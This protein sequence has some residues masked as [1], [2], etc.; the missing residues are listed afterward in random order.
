[1]EPA[2]IGAAAKLAHLLRVERGRSQ[3]IGPLVRL[4]V[5]DPADERETVRVNAG[6]RP[7]DHDVARPDS[8]SVDQLR[9]FDDSDAGAGEVELALTVDPRQLGGLPADE[10]APGL[11]AHLGRALD[12]LGDVVELN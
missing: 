11:T 7:A 10:R 4:L 5:E 2:N 1:H 6:G 8:R 3:Q 9:S 12:E